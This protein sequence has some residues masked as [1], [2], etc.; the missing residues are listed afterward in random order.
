MR[1]FDMVCPRRR[2]LM[3]Q[4]PIT[5]N[6]TPTMAAMCARVGRHD[7]GESG[8]AGEMTV[9]EKRTAARSRRKVLQDFTSSKMGHR[10]EHLWIPGKTKSPSFP[11]C[12]KT[13]NIPHPLRHYPPITRVS[14]PGKS[15]FV[16]ESGGFLLPTRALTI[17]IL[18]A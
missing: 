5:R 1:A 12:C 16:E 3:E 6:A 13:G 15:N 8:K 17:R 10:S 11:V 9:L 7:L 18:R 14:C 2:L 4:Q